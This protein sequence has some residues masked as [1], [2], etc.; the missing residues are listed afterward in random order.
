[1]DNVYTI[2]LC[3]LLCIKWGWFPIITYILINITRYLLAHAS[4]HLKSAMPC[5]PFFSEMMTWNTFP[6]EWFKML[7][8]LQL[9]S[10]NPKYITINYIFHSFIYG[11]IYVFSCILCTQTPQKQGNDGIITVYDSN[12][13]LI[14]IKKSINFNLYVKIINTQL[15]NLY[16]YLVIY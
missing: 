7:F 14:I 9:V 16:F 13:K 4:T 6:L 1:M 10:F 15:K 3:P 12:D 8:P 2:V 11:H 5:S